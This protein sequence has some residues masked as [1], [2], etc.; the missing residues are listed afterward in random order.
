MKIP[1]LERKLFVQGDFLE[2]ETH[3]IFSLPLSVQA[4][5]QLEEIQTVLLKRVWDEDTNDIWN[6]SWGPSE[7]SSKKAYNILIGNTEAYPLLSWL[8]TSN[9][10]GKHKIFFWLLLTSL[11]I[12]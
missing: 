10:L 6:Y 9:N 5:R 8:W 12:D 11:G 4:A 2:Q 3:R 1:D 7:Y